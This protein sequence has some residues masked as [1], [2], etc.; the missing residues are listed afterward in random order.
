ME[1]IID[2]SF[3]YDGSVNKS[4]DRECMYCTAVATG[5]CSKSSLQHGSNPE[6]CPTCY[7]AKERYCPHHC[8]IEHAMTLAKLDEEEKE[9]IRLYTK[10]TVGGVNKTRTVVHISS[11]EDD[12][13]RER[14]EISITSE[15]ET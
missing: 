7:A 15:N 3:H 11:Y 6:S 1:V 5:K 9:L 13:G 2:W 4:D 8:G 12:T 10:N 14:L